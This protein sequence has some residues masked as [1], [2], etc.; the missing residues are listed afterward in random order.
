MNYTGKDD[1]KT[2]RGDQGRVGGPMEGEEG[3]EWR[4]RRG[5]IGWR[6]STGGVMVCLT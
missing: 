3:K 6:W 2:L 1:V 5:R 4:C